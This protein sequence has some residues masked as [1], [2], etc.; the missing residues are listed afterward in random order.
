MASDPNKLWQLGSRISVT[1]QIVWSL[2]TINSD[3]ASA[4]AAAAAAA[5]AVTAAATVIAAAASAY[6]AASVL[7]SAWFLNNIK[8]IWQS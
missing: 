7:A 3:A 2:A 1:F 6:T 8:T 4:A 5:A